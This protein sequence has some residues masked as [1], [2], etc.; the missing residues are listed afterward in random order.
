VAGD[1]RHEGVHL[2]LR[3][4]HASEGGAGGVGVWLED[5]EE[6]L[7]GPTI[8]ESEELAW[9]CEGDGGWGDGEGFVGFHVGVCYRTREGEDFV[10][11]SKEKGE[12]GY[13]HRVK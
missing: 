13:I 9:D 12:S 10:F 6:L 8:C 4:Y 2:D 7:V 11:L 1:A 5:L 3:P